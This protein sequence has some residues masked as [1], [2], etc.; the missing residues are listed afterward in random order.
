MKTGKVQFSVD[1]ASKTTVYESDM[2][3]ALYVQS[4]DFLQV[5]GQLYIVTKKVWRFDRD[6]GA[7][8][9]Y[10]GLQILNPSQQP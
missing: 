10:Y 2:D 1:N 6:S 4:G 7:L 9:P 3:V 8:E 5:L